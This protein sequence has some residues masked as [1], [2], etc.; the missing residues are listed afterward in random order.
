MNNSNYYIQHICNKIEQMVNR[1]IKGFPDTIWLANKFEERNLFISGH[2]LARVFGVIPNANKPYKT[3]L[4]T[5]AHFLEYDNWDVYLQSHAEQLTK[6]NFFLSENA[7]GF[8][9]VTLK[10]ALDTKNYDEL[11]RILLLYNS[12]ELNEFHFYIANLIGLFVQENRT[13]EVLLEVLAKSR[14]GQSLFMGVLLMKRIKIIIFQE[15][16]FVII[17]QMYQLLKVRYL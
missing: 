8:S 1:K 6:N 7:N 2:T 9:E 4:D 11:H 14:A 5:L 12:Y 17:Y 13:D 16:Y 15:H 10:I 3:T